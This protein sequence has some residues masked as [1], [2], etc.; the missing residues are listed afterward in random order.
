MEEDVE[1]MQGPEDVAPEAVAPEAAPEITP[2]M[3]Q[4]TFKALE[5]R[6]LV[7]E[8]GG[9]AYVPTERGWKL[10][11]EIE[12]VKE[13]IIAYGHPAVAA[14]HKTALEITKASDIIKDADCIIGIK[15]NKACKDLKEKFKNA[16]KDAKKVE[17]TIEAGGVKDK[18]TAYGSPALRLTHAEDV[19]IRKTDFIDN[20]TVAILADKAAS[21]LKRDLVEMLKSSETKIKITL[22]IKP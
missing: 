6:G 22:E 12:P 14:T 20:R 13:E 1:K 15:A 7:Y 2:E 4:L 8:M 21:D 11:R 16:L 17:I 9:R 19:V 18:I 5:A 3:V 10:L